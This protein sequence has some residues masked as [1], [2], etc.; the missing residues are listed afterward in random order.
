MKRICDHR[1][2]NFAFKNSRES[3]EKKM[4]EKKHCG[5]FPVMQH[6]FHHTVSEASPRHDR[7]NAALWRDKTLDPHFSCPS[8]CRFRVSIKHTVF[9]FQFRCV[10]AYALSLLFIFGFNPKWQYPIA[11]TLLELLILNKVVLFYFIFSGICLWFCV[12]ASCRV[13][14]LT[15]THTHT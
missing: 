15:H 8:L 5:N 11:K 12:H 14:V 9:P 1:N 2:S 13:T 4:R 10:C 3:T 6:A 7:Q